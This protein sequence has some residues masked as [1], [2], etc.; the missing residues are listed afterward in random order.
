MN[1]ILQKAVFLSALLVCISLSCQVAEEPD[2]LSI[3]PV[4]QLS[5]ITDTLKVANGKLDYRDSFYQGAFQAKSTVRSEKYIFS[6]LTL[7]LTLNLIGTIIAASTVSEGPPANIPDL[8]EEKGFSDGYHRQAISSHKAAAISGGLIG[9]T[10]QIVILV[11]I[12]KNILG[13]LRS[14][15]NILS[16]RMMKSY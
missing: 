6:G 11:A 15:N 16:F 12:L 2:T 3:V 7:G 1:K 10:I 4:Q 5:E 9:S 8:Y 13:D 14:P